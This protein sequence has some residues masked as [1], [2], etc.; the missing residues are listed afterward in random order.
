MR[1]GSASALTPWTRPT[2]MGFLIISHHSVTFGELVCFSKT[3]VFW[4]MP[5]SHHTSPQHTFPTPGRL[6]AL[7]KT[8]CFSTYRGAREVFSS[9]PI[10]WLHLEKQYFFRIFLI[11]Y[12]FSHAPKPRYPPPVDFPHASGTPLDASERCEKHVFEHFPRC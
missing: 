8:R 4:R 9:F 3:N 7:R 1:V 10:I 11:F 2:F 5:P 12:I 6:P